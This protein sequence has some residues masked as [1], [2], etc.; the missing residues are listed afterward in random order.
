MQRMQVYG[1]VLNMRIVEHTAFIKLNM[2][3]V[4]KADGAKKI[5]NEIARFSLDYGE[6]TPISEST[7]N[8]LFEGDMITMY[9][10]QKDLFTYT[11]ADIKVEKNLSLGD[12]ITKA[13]S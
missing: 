7:I 8:L 5:T 9:L 10:E 3:E 13:L 6:N 12:A 1:M 11:T 4:V 2:L